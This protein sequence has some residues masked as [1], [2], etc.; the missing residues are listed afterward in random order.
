MFSPHH[1]TPC[2]G[3]PAPSPKQ[4][5]HPVLQIRG[6]PLGFGGSP[7]TSQPMSRGQ[8]HNPTLRVPSRPPPRA[9]I[10]TVPG[11]AGWRAVMPGSPF[12]LRP[13]SSHPSPDSQRKTTSR[14]SSAGLW[15]EASS[16]LWTAPPQDP[17]SAPRGQTDL[18]SAPLEPVGGL[19]PLG[20]SN[21]GCFVYPCLSQPGSW[22]A[23]CGLGP[24]THY[25]L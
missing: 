17:G 9:V 1:P 8:P 25:S 19:Q 10:R 16:W 4:D 6:A 22:E 15:R 5:C 18:G 24:S 23:F 3:L 11:P 20:R 7:G 13:A 14:L 12:T 21:P 2:L